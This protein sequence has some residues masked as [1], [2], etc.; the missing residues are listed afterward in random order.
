MPIHHTSYLLALLLYLSTTPLLL[1]GQEPEPEEETADYV[2]TI[3]RYEDAVY[4]KDIKTVL[5]HR[6]EHV[7]ALPMLEMGE[8]MQLKLSFDLLGDEPLNLSYTVIHCKADWSGP[9]EISHFDYIDGYSEE[10]INDYFYAHK[11]QQD[12]L[13]YELLFPN[14]RMNLTKSGNYLLKV[15]EEGNPDA[16]ILTRRFV[17]YE[18]LVGIDSYQMANGIIFQHFNT[19]QQLSFSLDHSFLTEANPISDFYV[20]VLQNG[21]WYNQLSGLSYNNYALNRL[22]YRITGRPIFYGGDEFRYVDFRALHDPGERIDWVDLESIPAH[23]YMVKDEI[24]TKQKSFFNLNQ[25]DLNGQ[26]RIGIFRK[27][28]L[29][30]QDPDYAYV[31]F[32]L[33]MEE[34]LKT[35]NLYVFG[36]LSHWNLLPEFQMHY[37]REFK[38]YEA[39]ILLKQGYY[40]FQYVV[41]EDDSGDLTNMQIRSIDKDIRIIEN[42]YFILIYYR[43]AGS[44]FDRLVGVKRVSGLF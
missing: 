12:Y 43:H 5:L 6:L 8:P 38:H 37:N 2:S 3:M 35:G 23:V 44:W 7:L 26:Y 18:Q 22:N 25:R 24:R 34:P 11:T 9:S 4:H 32:K 20:T 1:L 33:A 28:L 10:D 41:V 27:K 14:N 13:H 15:Y 31:H 42:D 29:S 36:A 16:L 30:A 17:I 39:T 21:Q 19:H 40:D